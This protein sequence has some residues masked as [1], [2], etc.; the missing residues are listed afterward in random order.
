MGTNTKHAIILKTITNNHICPRKAKRAETIT[1]CLLRK[2]ANTKD[3]SN[4]NRN[5]LIYC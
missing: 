2:M 3:L 1:D 5:I 4:K